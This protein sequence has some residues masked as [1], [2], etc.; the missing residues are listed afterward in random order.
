MKKAIWGG[1]VSLLIILFVCVSLLV[2]EGN[3]LK[4][5]YDILIVLVPV[6]V[7]L[8]IYDSRK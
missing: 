1:F 5:L 3:Q 6:S 8:V 4:G 7:A 2:N